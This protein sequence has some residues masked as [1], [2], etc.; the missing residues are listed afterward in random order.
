MIHLRLFQLLTR[1]LF[2]TIGPRQTELRQGLLIEPHGARLMETAIGLR[3]LELLLYATGI[4]LNELQL[5]FIGFE[6]ILLI[7]DPP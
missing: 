6:N 5:I 2:G 3:P 4:H 1:G 7:V